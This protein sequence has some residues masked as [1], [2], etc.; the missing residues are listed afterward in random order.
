MFLEIGEN[1]FNVSDAVKGITVKG[2]IVETSACNL[3]VIR[4]FLLGTLRR[5]LRVDSAPTHLRVS[6]K[7]SDIPADLRWECT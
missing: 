7:T 2:A 6:A 1:D 3:S 5:I 4:C